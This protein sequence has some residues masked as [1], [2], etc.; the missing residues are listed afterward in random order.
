MEKSKRNKKE[1]VEEEEE[2]EEIEEEEEVEDELGEDFA[3]DVRCMAYLTDAG[4]V[5]DCKY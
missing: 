2:I 1:E 5:A 3:K 4:K